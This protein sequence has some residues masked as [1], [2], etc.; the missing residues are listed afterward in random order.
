MEVRHGASH[1]QCGVDPTRTTA[2]LAGTNTVRSPSLEPIEYTMTPTDTVADMLFGMSGTAP[3]CTAPTSNAFYV[4][5][6]AMNRLQSVD[7]HCIAVQCRGRSSKFSQFTIQCPMQH[8]YIYS[9]GTLQHVME[10]KNI[11]NLPILT[12]M[13]LS[14]IFFIK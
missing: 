5:T 2:T 1:E 7:T 13:I 3:T 6:P 11:Q 12:N 8:M 10:L 4:P 9:H 14:K